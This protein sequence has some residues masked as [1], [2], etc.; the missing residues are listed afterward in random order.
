MFGKKKQLTEQQK[1]NRKQG[2]LKT[3]DAS[4]KKYQKKAAEKTRS[5]DF[6]A[7]FNN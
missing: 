6:F 7:G 4:A 3:E 2:I 5:K 1:K